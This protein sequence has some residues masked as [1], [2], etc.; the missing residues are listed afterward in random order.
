VFILPHISIWNLILLLGDVGVF[1]LSVAAG[2]IFNPKAGS[3]PLA[4]LFKYSPS[5]LLVGGVYIAVLYIADLYDYQQDFRKR[6]NVA[7]LVSGAWLGTL[8]VVILFYFPLGAFIGRILLIMQATTF[9]LLLVLWRVTFS[10]VAPHR[11]LERPLYIVGAG[12]AGQELAAAFRARP[13]SGL[14]IRGFVDDNPL[15]WGTTVEGLPVLGDSCRMQEIMSGDA[16][17]VIAVAITHEKSP[18][19]ISSL[20]QASW[21]GCQILDMPTLYEILEGKIP[22]DHI[23]DV[24][25]FLNSLHPP[26]YY[27]KIKNVTDRVLALLGLLVTAFLFPLIALAIRL[28][29]PGPIFFIQERLGKEGRPFKIIKFR[30]MVVDAEA[31]GPQFASRDDPRITRVGW[32]LRK[33]R[34]D[35]LPQLLNIL[36]GEM[37]FVG[38]RP[39]REVFIREYQEAVTLYRPGRRAGDP[40]GTLVACGIREKVPYYSYRLLVK[41]GLT[42]WAQVM[43]SYAAS[44]DESREKLMYDLY[45][46]KNMG[47]FLDAGILLKTL[48]T[49]LFG[50]G[51]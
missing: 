17:C 21:S 38:P 47:F 27:L 49:V 13:G 8:M 23:S 31:E 50:R 48:R 29:S 10:A 19:L 3:Q 35:E 20:S 25:L 11:R 46:I 51:T 7:R 43:L 6:V 32:V 45:Y 15:K 5:V 44:L 42:G 18:G 16:G 28:E 41:P 24:W 1:F 9:C 39:E 33:L 36:K 26:R 2:L 14:M 37:S 40:P 22:I 4:L 34:L 30:T 12:R